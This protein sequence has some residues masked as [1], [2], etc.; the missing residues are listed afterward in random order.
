[1]SF[2][3]AQGA[4]SRILVE[5]GA[6]PHVFDSNSEFTHYQRHNIRKKGRIVDSNAIRGT[7]SRHKAFTRYGQ[8]DVRGTL[9]LDAQPNLLDTWIPR[10]FGGSLSSGAVALAETLPYFGMLLDEVGAIFTVTDAMVNAAEI[11]SR[12]GV[13]DSQPD[14]VQI[15][16]DIMAKDMTTTYKQ[17]GPLST[18]TGDEEGT[19][20]M[21]S[22]EHGIEEGDLIDVYWDGGRRSGVTVDTVSDEDVTFSGG[23]G[24]DLPAEDTDT[25]TSAA[26]PATPPTEPLTN[27]APYLHSDATI[28]LFGSERDVIAWRLRVNNFL[29]TRR[30][31][32]L[33]AAAFCPQDREVEIGVTVPFS[34]S[35]FAAL[36]AR[37]IAGGTATITL[38]NENM[39]ASFTCPALQVPDNPPE[40]KGKAEIEM[41]LV[42]IARMSGGTREIAATLDSTP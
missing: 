2:E 23:T 24:D 4:L 12:A 16:L 40:V 31:N 6:S 37:P 34:S 15:A 32:S 27:A 1:M 26:W 30:V 10:I 39:S 3:C 42:G 7:R 41:E 9:I 22:A 38:T 28:S 35:E 21:N 5:P 14:L 29:Y 13:D 11:R 36:Y 18:R 33:T 20:T 17:G 8:N 19:I 25:R